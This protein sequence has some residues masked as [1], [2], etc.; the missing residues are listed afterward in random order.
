METITDL[1]SP[2]VSQPCSDIWYF[3]MHDIL[4]VLFFFSLKH[5]LGAE[6]WISV[7]LSHCL[8]SPSWVHCL[9]IGCIQSKQQILTSLH[10]GRHVM[11]SVVLF[12]LQ[13]NLIAKNVHV[14]QLPKHFW[15]VHWSSAVVCLPCPRFCFPQAMT[16]SAPPSLITRGK[17]WLSCA[18]RS[19]LYGS[20]SIKAVLGVLLALEENQQLGKR[21]LSLIRLEDFR[22]CFLPV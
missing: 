14:W 12:V 9:F 13:C 5:H 18:K 8:L 7:C 21:L 16:S 20:V 4:G 22:F 15:S 1:S 11:W 2:W 17:L 19:L 6:M 10:H 3:S